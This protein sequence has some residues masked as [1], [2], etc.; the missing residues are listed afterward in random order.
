MPWTIPLTDEQIDNFTDGDDDV[1]LWRVLTH[2]TGASI[3]VTQTA[4]GTD[5]Y[6]TSLGDLTGISTTKPAHLLILHGSDISSGAGTH[7]WRLVDGSAST[8]ASGTLTVWDQTSFNFDPNQLIEIDGADWTGHNLSDV[9][10]EID[11]VWSSGTYVF[12]IFNIRMHYENAS[13][14]AP[15]IVDQVETILTATDTSHDVDMPTTVVAGQTLIVGVVMFDSVAVSTPS[16]WTEIEHQD[17]SSA[18][19]TVAV[20]AKDAVGD[21]DGTSVDFVTD[22]SVRGIGHC[23][24]VEGTSVAQILSEFN[25]SGGFGSIGAPSWDLGA[26]VPVTVLTFAGWDDDSASYYYVDGFSPEYPLSVPIVSQTGQGSDDVTLLS[27]SVWDSFGFPS[28]GAESPN[29][30]D[31]LM[32]QLVLKSNDWDTYPTLTGGGTSQFTVDSTFIIPSLPVSFSEG[33]L[34]MAMVF[35][36]GTG[37]LTCGTSGWVQW[38]DSPIESTENDGFRLSL[39]WKIHEGAG[40]SSSVSF[41]NPGGG[42]ILGQW[43]AFDKIDTSDPFGASNFGENA[44][45]VGANQTFPLVDP[46]ESN[47]LILVIVA[48]ED[49]TSSSARWESFRAT[50]EGIDYFRHTSSSGWLLTGS[51]GAQVAGAG[52]VSVYGTKSGTVSLDDLELDAVQIATDFNT[53]YFAIEIKG[54][55]PLSVGHTTDAVLQ[56]VF[57]QDHT[58]DA[59][60]IA[61]DVTRTHTT[62]ALKVPPPQFAR[63][64]SDLITTNWETAPTP[65][66]SLFEQLNESTADPNDFIYWDP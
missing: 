54:I 21:E 5:T 52:L 38:T 36:Q 29:P 40:E 28:W 37:D 6:I 31:G 16:G 19:P 60:K 50:P 42:R 65:S 41:G 8:I 2:E 44:D 47:S 64:D 46:E 3:E 7:P 12:Q 22:S 63:P 32:I 27:Y 66:Q 11:S 15:V 17:F 43:L 51:K 35:S 48:D 18:S 4:S 25:D 10:L 55:Q 57:T 39:W 53:A 56:F 26:A 14:I 45:S 30:G 62:N 20:Y 59:I 58:T 49:G 9:T 33:D 24:L 61:E 13:S 34:M 23:Y 1:D